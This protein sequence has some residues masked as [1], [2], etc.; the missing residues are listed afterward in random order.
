LPRSGPATAWSLI[1]G[2][3]TRHF[4]QRAWGGRSWDL[5]CIAPARNQTVT[6]SE[7]ASYSTAHTMG[8]VS[9]NLLFGVVVGLLMVGC[10]NPVAVS[11]VG[12]IQ[13]HVYSWACGAPFERNACNMPVR[14]LQLRFDGGN[15]HNIFHV[16]TDVTG[17]YSLSLPPGTYVVEH[18][19]TNR[20]AVMLAPPDYGP[21]TV[22]LASRDH[23]V[24]DFALRAGSRP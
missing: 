21:R 4:R 7:T 18:E 1:P 23:V 10:G 9:R 3:F 2:V 6:F 13:G 5:S 12:Q 15:G 20:D 24:A 17:A 11:G 8:I 22:T 19:W 16:V 14:D